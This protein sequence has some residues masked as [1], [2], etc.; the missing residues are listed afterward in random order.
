MRSRGPVP[1]KESD[2]TLNRT[3]WP[4]V[5]EGKHCAVAAPVGAVS[6]SPGAGS[7]LMAPFAVRPGGL[8]IPGAATR[9]LAVSKPI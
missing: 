4:A 6:R 8:V 3:P 1:V 7:G 9:R 2:P 5:L